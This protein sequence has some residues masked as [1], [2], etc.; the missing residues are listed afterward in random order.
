VELGYIYTLSLTSAI[1]GVG[2]QRHTPSALP[3]GKRQVIQ[4]TGCCLGPAPICMLA[5]NRASPA[6]DHR[7]VQ[8]V[9]SRCTDYAITGYEITIKGV[10]MS[11]GNFDFFFFLR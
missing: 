2:G 8:S 11:T 7:I 3:A 10:K 4:F 5:E 9:E 6:S 1:V